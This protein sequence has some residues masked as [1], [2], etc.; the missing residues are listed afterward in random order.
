MSAEASSPLP[1]G[2]RALAERR[3][4]ALGALDASTLD[5]TARAPVLL[6]HVDGESAGRAFGL[7]AI[8][9]DRAILSAFTH[10]HD[11]RREADIIGALEAAIRSRRLLDEGWLR[12]ERVLLPTTTLSRDVTEEYKRLGFTHFYT[13]HELHRSLDELPALAVPAGIEITP[14]TR[15]RDAEIREA[16]NDAFG[17]RGF[18]GFDKDDW[19]GATFSAQEG[20]RADLSFLAI[21]G[22][23]IAGFCLCEDAHA[24]NIGWID[25]LGVRPK[26]RSRG[27]ATA[28]TIRAMHAMRDASLT[29]AGLRVNVDNA[30]ARRLYDRLGF[31]LF[32]QHIVYRKRIA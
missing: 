18:E 3:D 4:A 7:A 10:P 23:V 22:G 8:D 32:K 30:R 12:I 16:Y 6:T 2:L 13:E 21:A 27:V 26:H 19:A 14:W 29:A 20:F 25:T 5:R 1:D 24:P 28:L 15:D 11:A 9:G 17:D 31:R